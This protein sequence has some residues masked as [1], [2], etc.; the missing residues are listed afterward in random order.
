M[1]QPQAARAATRSVTRPLHFPTTS[2]GLVAAISAAD[3]AIAWRR[4]YPVEDPLGDTIV[5][6]KPSCVVAASKGGRT[7]R[8][9]DA[10]EGAL[11]WEALV[12]PQA[13]ARAALAAL[14]LK[15]GAAVAI[16]AGGEVQVGSQRV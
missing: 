6:S 1:R 5:L 2:Q 8:A 4:T 3:G 11:K 13:G 16:A 9:W 7:V 14:A 12:A 10:A 15:D